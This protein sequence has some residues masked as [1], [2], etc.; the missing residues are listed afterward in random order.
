MDIATF[1]SR[2]LHVLTAAAL[3]G[4]AV[5]VRFALLPAAKELPDDV[6]DGLRARLKAKWKMWVMGGITLLLVTGFYNYLVVAS[7][8]HKAAGDSRY[9]MFMGIKIVVA[10]VVF[11]LASVLTGRS[12]KFE[13]MRKAP[14]NALTILLVAA[15][16][17]IGIGSFLK[18]RGI[19]KASPTNISTS[20]ES[21]E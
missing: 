17:V 14:R 6:H 11:F 10:L 13:A 20:S 9:H 5:Y 1:L 15:A 8:A 4:G 7:P 19:P 21:T 2:F 16:I 18:I 3:V 12:A